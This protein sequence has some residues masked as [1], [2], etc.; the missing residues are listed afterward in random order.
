M[1]Q[2]GLNIYH[3]T[4]WIA[5]YHKEIEARFIDALNHLPS[6]GSEVDAALQEYITCVADW[7]RGNDC[8]RFESERYFG[9]KGPEVQRTRNVRMFAKRVMNPDMRRDKVEVPLVEE[10]E[11]IS[12]AATIEA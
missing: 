5:N 10:L 2:F 8:W 6:F 9:K 1:H 4:E 7:P 3:A 11:Q 12:F